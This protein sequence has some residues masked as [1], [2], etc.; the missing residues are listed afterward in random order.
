MIVRSYDFSVSEL[1]ESY[2]DCRK[3]KRNTPAAIK[4]EQNLE[5]NLMNLYHQLSEETWEP[6]PATVFAITKPKPREVWAA[7]F[8]DRIVHHLIYRAVG[9]VFEKSFIHDSCACIKGR[10]TLYAANRVEQ[11]LRKCTQD[12]TVPA[13]ILKVD[14]ANFFGS[15]QQGLLFENNMLPQ[16]TNCRM[17]GFEA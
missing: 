11:H 10:G 17:S 2:Y 9:P 5:E 15:I 1:F 12:W 8:K 13:Y 7:E 4:F 6:S 3:R 16:N 14:V